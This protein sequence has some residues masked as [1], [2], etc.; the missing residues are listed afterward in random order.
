MS[1]AGAEKPRQEQHA[2]PQTGGAEDRTDLAALQI[3]EIYL[4]TGVG[5]SGE[6]GWRNAVLI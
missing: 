3:V 1:V 6:R 4:P 2:H 5:G